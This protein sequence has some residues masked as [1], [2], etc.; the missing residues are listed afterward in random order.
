FDLPIVIQDKMFADDGS[1]VFDPLNHDGFLGDTYV[2]NGKVQPFFNVQQRRYR[3]RFLNG[4]P[5]RFYELF[6]TNSRGVP[7]PMAAIATEG[8]LLD[9]AIVLTHFPLS[10]A[11]RIEVIV[12]FSQFKKG[13][14]VF[15]EN[16]LAQDDGRGPRGTFENPEIRPSGTRLVKFVVG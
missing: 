4:S 15:L 6:V 5:A 11:E 16:R 1:L 12:D 13:D 7:A 14:E 9:H 3:F 2:I 8:G 10:P